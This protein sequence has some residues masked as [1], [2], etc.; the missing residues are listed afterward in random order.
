[1]G[2]PRKKIDPK[3][4]EQLARIQCSYEE[5]AAVL[6]C[7]PSTLTRRF[8]QV[9]KKG[10][11]N[12]RSSLKRAQYTLAVGTKA[13]FDEKGNEIIA[14]RGANP[15]MLIWLGKQHLGQQDK[16]AH[17]HSGPAGG[18]IEVR[19]NEL[20]DRIASRIAGIATRI[21]PAADH[22][23]THGNGTGGA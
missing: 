3:Q 6:D 1:M 20:R 22:S 7:D 10:R 9:I 23:G 21:G 12:G 8:A 16:Q 2:R 14:E 17:E 18:P 5:M 15:T 19:T 4:L 13:Q 11:E